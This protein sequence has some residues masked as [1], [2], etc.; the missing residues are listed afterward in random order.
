MSGVRSLKS[1]IESNKHIHTQM[2]RVDFNMLFHMLV[3]VYSNELSHDNFNNDCFKLESAGH[4]CLVP[5]AYR[6][7]GCL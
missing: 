6:L 5:I 4:K 1:I 3:N 7:G 2:Y